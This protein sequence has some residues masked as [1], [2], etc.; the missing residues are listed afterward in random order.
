MHPWTFIHIADMQPGSP[1]SFRYKAAW[2]EN[3][4]TAMQQ[5][6]GMNPDLILV[7]GDVT[8][9]GSIHDFELAQARRDFDSLG[10]PCH[11]IP[12]NMDTGNKHA[13]CQG[14]KADRDDMSLNVTSRQLGNFEKHFGPNHWTFVHKNVRFTGFYAAAAGSGLPEEKAMWQMLE[15]LPDL[16]RAEHHVVMTHYAPF[17]HDIDEDDFDL[18]KEAEYHSWYFGIDRAHRRRM[19][20]LLRRAGATIWISGHIHCYKTDRIGDILFI[21]APATCMSQMTAHWP[22]A[23]GTLGFLRFDVT[24]EGIHHTLVPL[25]NVSQNPAAYGPGG[26]PKPETR[27]YSLAWERGETDR[28]APA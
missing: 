20:E 26:H 7:G 24:D 13:P 11:I 17:M 12:G 2:G 4:Q 8:R 22:D 25:T 1:R 10:R 9:D 23:N 28:E 18:T 3:W 19:L 21:K 14:A 5:I 6:R 15:G 27:D 16:P